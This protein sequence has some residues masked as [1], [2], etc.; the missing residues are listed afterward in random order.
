[1]KHARKLASLLLALVMV[2]ALATTAFA[3]EPEGTTTTPTGSITVDNPVAEQEYKAYKIF[4]VVYDAAKKYYSY[5]IKG[6]SEW[7]DTVNDYAIP[8]HGLTLTKVGATDTYVVTIDE[9]QFSAP[10]FAAALKTALATLTT[11]TDVHNFTENSDGTKVASSLPLGYYFV[12]SDAADA[13]CNLTTTNPAVTIHDKNDMPFEKEVWEKDVE[14]GQTVHY[15]ITGKVPDH[16]GFNA[17]TYLITDTMTDGLTF[18]K[19][20]VKVTINGANVAQEPNGYTLTEPNDTENFTFKLSINVKNFKIGDDIEVIYN[21]T[22]NKNAIAEIESNKATLTYTN[23]PTVDEDKTTTERE[24]KVYTSK[25]VIDKYEKGDNETKLEGA[26]FVLCRKAPDDGPQFATVLNDSQ[27][28]IKI[29]YYKQDETTKAVSWVDDIA[30]ATKVTT[31]K[32]GAAFF[33]GLAD[34]TYHLV[35]TKAPA[36]YNRMTTDQEVVVKGGTKVADLSV[37]AKVENQA[38][39]LLPSTG[40]VGTTV[41]YVLGAVLVLGAVVLLVTK[42]RMN[43]ANR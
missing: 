11:I 16:T 31:D 12:K 5:T 22:V 8:N 42:K 20:S 17:Y 13:L 40:G 9:N 35:E 18:D 1:M 28:T 27:K 30:D 39:T 36:G 6:T 32:S 24:V 4:D 21:A 43:D 26:E 3:T 19:T 37:T 33:E 7:F 25:I 10:S 41:F 38:G 23:G 34:G 14:V 2:F 29:Q 15:M